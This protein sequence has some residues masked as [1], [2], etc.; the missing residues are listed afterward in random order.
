MSVPFLKLWIV[1]LVKFRFF[2]DL[3]LAQ[4]D[5]RDF[6]MDCL[7]LETKGSKCCRNMGHH[8][9][10]DT[11]QFPRKSEKGLTG[12][13]ENVGFKPPHGALITQNMI[14]F[15]QLIIGTQPVTYKSFLRC[16]QVINSFV[17]Q[18]QACL[19]VTKVKW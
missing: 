8:T 11:V 9:P 7:T 10:N 17:R 12:S 2:R 3:S 13:S 18:T 5:S 1:L 16:S 14:A 6:F 4:H 15:L 19:S